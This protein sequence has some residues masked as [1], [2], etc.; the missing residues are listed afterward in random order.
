MVTHPW[1]IGTSKNFTEYILGTPLSPSN[2]ACRSPES[3]TEYLVF[4]LDII[5]ALLRYLLTDSRQEIDL[6]VFGRGHKA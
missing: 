6:F 5:G 4:E 3:L 2:E 1:S